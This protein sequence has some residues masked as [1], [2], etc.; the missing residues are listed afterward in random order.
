[1]KG[2]GGKKGDRITPKISYNFSNAV[3]P[4]STPLVLQTGERRYIG[5]FGAVATLRNEEAIASSLYDR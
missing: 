4:I 3:A 5:A 2:W 1:V